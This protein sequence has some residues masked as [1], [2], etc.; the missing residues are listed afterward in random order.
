MDYTQVK[1]GDDT[2]CF[3]RSWHTWGQSEGIRAFLLVFS[4]TSKAAV[5][6]TIPLRHIPLLERY[7][8]RADDVRGGN[9][10]SHHPTWVSCGSPPAPDNAKDP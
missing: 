9:C 3:S 1:G 8:V 6:V 5:P 7:G 2:R 10:P 4:Y